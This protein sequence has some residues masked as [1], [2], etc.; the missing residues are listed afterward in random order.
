MTETTSDA[1]EKEVFSRLVETQDQGASVADSRQRVAEEFQ[2]S[3][4]D[5]V[6]IE[7]KGIAGTW[8]PL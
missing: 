2:L 6:D 4:D 8:P 3:V 7:R 1:R 5:V